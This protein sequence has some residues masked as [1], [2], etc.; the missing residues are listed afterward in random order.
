MSIE[1][2]IETKIKTKEFAFKFESAERADQAAQSFN[3]LP[4]LFLSKLQDTSDINNNTS[5]NTINPNNI[6]YVKL[7]NSRFLPEIELCCDDSSGNFFTDLYPLDH[8]TLLSIFVKSNSNITLPIRMDFRITEFETV[9]SDSSPKLNYL[10]KGII[11]LDDLHYTNY[12]V[13]PK[14][15]SY[16]VLKDIALKMNLGFVSNVV[17]SDD[18]M[19]WINPS[20][21]YIDFIRD[22]T[23]RSYIDENSFVWTFID[24]YYRLNYMNIGLELTTTT[25]ELQNFSSIPLTK[26]DQE[27]NTNT[28]KINVDKD[29]NTT[30]DYG[31]GNNIPAW[32]QAG[33]GPAIANVPTPDTTIPGPVSSSSVTTPP[34]TNAA[35]P[36]ELFLTN[37]SA[38]K[39]APSKYISNFYLIN[40]SYKVNLDKSYRMKVTWYKKDENTTCRDFLNDIESTE[41]NIKPLY[42]YNSE[43]YNENINDEYYLGKLESDNVHKYYAVSKAINEFNLDNLEKMKM[44]VTIN[45]TNFDIKRFQNLRIDIYNINDMFSSDSDKKV[46]DI[47]PDNKTSEK[48]NEKLSGYWLV[49]GINYIFRRSGGM[50][51]EMTLVRRDLNGVNDYIAKPTQ[52]TECAKQKSGDESG[53]GNVENMSVGGSQDQKNSYIGIDPTGNPTLN[54]VGETPAWI[55]AGMGNT[56]SVIG[57]YNGAT[58]ITPT[59]TP[60]NLADEVNPNAASGL[61]AP[62]SNQGNYIKK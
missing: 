41:S 25:P 35:K 6:I 38:A 28:S 9:K 62:P 37:S 55:Q 54:L 31:G 15:T 4:F 21:T 48:K 14:T 60:V 56:G 57:T 50:A 49:T 47:Q 16:N 23:N 39:S 12:E 27:A 11:N 52:C 30:I 44:V 29:G 59:P 7:H 58:Y 40:R 32:K 42:D 18:E 51:Q 61:Y 26:N 13:F 43:L 2:K 45:Q 33:M 1:T 19:T 5:G 36:V 34:A 22:T 24:F 53:S 3:Y 46:T 17:G 10:I 8:D 20:E